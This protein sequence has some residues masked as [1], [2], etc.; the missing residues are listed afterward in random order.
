MSWFIALVYG[1]ATAVVAILLHQT[2]PP[3]GVV[4]SLILSYLSIW[5]IG[6]R[7]GRRGYKFLAAVGWITVL[8]R[9][10][11]FGEGQELLVQG[12]AVGSTLLLLGT[13]TVL[14][15]VAARV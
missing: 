10:S 2:L 11:L 12:D 5:S 8:L 1:G 4:C 3:Y 13:L 6:R 14:A 7:Y 9:G 15:A